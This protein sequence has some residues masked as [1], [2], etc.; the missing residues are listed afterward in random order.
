MDLRRTRYGILALLA[1]TVCASAGCSGDHH[2]VA[3]PGDTLSVSATSL[4]P[5]T[6][7]RGT[8]SVPMLK[9]VMTVSGAQD[10]AVTWT[11]IRVTRSGQNDNGSVDNVIVARDDG[12]GVWGGLSV[13]LPIGSTGTWGA[14][15]T[16]RV[17]VAPQT[18]T[19]GSPGTYFVVFSIPY[20]A[21]GGDNVAAALAGSVAIVASGSDAVQLAATSSAPATIALPVPPAGTFIRTGDMGSARGYQ[22]ATLL[23]D[24]RVLV[25]GGLDDGDVTTASADLYDP[26]RGVFSPA[27]N[28]MSAGRKFHTATLLA[29]NTVLV[30]GGYDTTTP[31]PGQTDSADLFDPATSTF[32]PTGGRMTS[33][34]QDHAET[35]LPGGKVLITGGATTGGPLD[36]AELYDPATGTFAPTNGIMGSRRKYHTATRLP[37][38]KVLVAGGDNGAA[39]ADAELYDPATDAFSPTGPMNAARSSHTA[40]LLGNGTVLVTGGIGPGFATLSS[41]EVYDPATGTFS[42]TTT[43]MTEGRAYH[44]AS[45]LQNGKVLVTG[46]YRGGSLATAELFDPATGSFSATGNMAVKRNYH[47][48]TLLPDGIVLVTGGF[49]QSSSVPSAELYY[50]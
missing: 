9:L 37:G 16:A 41:A 48:S 6:V 31:T 47:T 21:A 43:P 49:V 18:V 32:R 39:L 4:A 25:A 34:R 15:N 13:D 14:G 46:G 28:A 19:G 12:D 27:P 45:R 17:V 23:R 1:Y 30:A 11:E 40:T 20:G 33:P 7:E 10:N 5:A 24:G 42:P 50:P 26:V 36:S 3:A 44:E 29:D 35:I 38:G 2:A 8:G 22:T